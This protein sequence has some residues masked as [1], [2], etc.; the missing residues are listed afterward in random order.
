MSRDT[1]P[2]QA[3][4]H[5]RTTGWRS[6][7]AA[8]LAGLLLCAAGSGAQA[9]VEGR[10][11]QVGF[12]GEAGTCYRRGAWCPVRV[13]L[14]LRGAPSFSGVLR[15]SQPDADADVCMSEVPVALSGEG[16]SRSYWLYAVPN[17]SS[18]G[19]RGDDPI[20]VSLID[21]TGTAVLFEDPFGERSPR[22]VSR[23]A[24]V[25][26]EPQE[27]LLLDMS[28]QPLSR[29]GGAVG[30]MGDTLRRSVRLARTSPEN[31][32]T[33]W[34]GLEMAD[35]IVWDAPEPSALEYRQTDALIEWVRRG[36]HLVLA[37]S[38]TAG[39]LSQSALGPLLPVEAG[40]V[41]SRRNMLEVQRRVLGMA[42]GEELPR[43]VIVSRTA[44]RPGARVKVNDEGLPFISVQPV[45]QGSVTFVAAELRDLW[46]LEPAD[47]PEFVAESQAREKEILRSRA[48]LNTLFGLR[49]RSVRGSERGLNLNPTWLFQ[50]VK[51]TV[52]F[53]ARSGV[54]MGIAILF[55]VAYV[56]CATVVSWN[57]LKRK[58]WTHLNWTA[59][60]VVVL[61]ASGLSL[62]AVRVVRGITTELH[63]LSVVDLHSDSYKATATCYFGLKTAKHTE[64]DLW[65]PSD[66]SRPAGE[67]PSMCALKPMPPALEDG[68]ESRGFLSPQ[69]YR[70][71]PVRAQLEDVPLRATLKQFVGDWSGE[72]STRV[73][74]ELRM[75]SG[76]ILDASWIENGL[77]V[78]LEGCY[79]LV[80]RFDPSME[81]AAGLIDV[82]D[83]G[84]IKAGQRIE[85][86][87]SH[88]RE[89]A[90]ARGGRA[91]RRS[92]EPQ[93]AP[94]LKDLHKQWARDLDP[95]M[96][97]FG[98]PQQ[99][100]IDPENY[101]KALLLLTTLREYEPET[102]GTGLGDPDMEATH[103]R[104]LDRSDLLTRDTALLV[105][106]SK[107]AGP[108]RL[109][110]RS[111]KK[112]QNG[113]E[114]RE[115]REAR[116]MY[117]VLV[118]VLQ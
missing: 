88:V 31:M 56:L 84:T 41:E 116:T 8:W 105:G 21:D 55:V 92:E 4:T 109:T 100:E 49:Q 115:P 33:A 52:D 58:E 12:L 77:D 25:P 15:V 112:K 118:P 61:A 2:M 71:R 50:H 3:D 37:A 75:S 62:A 5:D 102:S 97:P 53:R 68:R 69:M 80:A 10:I 38:R 104:T 111:S 89:Q 79:L 24:V 95:S 114:T 76:E 23:E 54:F 22:L 65:L 47:P 81:R 103:G 45:G 34:F 90:D 9:A 36:G 107:D 74:C 17:P 6:R 78:D 91:A 57:W 59:F 108:V 29:L 42:D 93:R 101:D 72:I 27:I 14:T 64:L 26:L 43:E 7:R 70:A 66:P 73:R 16:N 110:L 40:P 30:D 63:Q 117:R 13:E 113:F 18:V 99:R 82:H 19:R 46:R 85:R 86:L 20:E 87:G 106:F 60:A 39:A 94:T 67:Q 96:L 35:F 48:L 11:I 32:P 44:L 28:A 51:R 83:V 98:G 1:S